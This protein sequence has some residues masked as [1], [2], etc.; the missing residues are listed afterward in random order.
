MNERSHE[1]VGL[2]VKCEKTLPIDFFDA[3]AVEY[4]RLNNSIGSF[5]YFYD[6]LDDAFWC[7]TFGRL[8]QQSDWFIRCICLM[9][10]S[11]NVKAEHVTTT[12]VKKPNGT[13][14][15]R[16]S[17]RLKNWAKN[18]DIKSAQILLPTDYVTMLYCP[19][20]SRAMPSGHVRWMRIARPF[21]RHCNRGPT[22]ELNNS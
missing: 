2:G 13:W 6:Y 3:R 20:E 21:C 9:K 1:S 22:S 12:I 14:H 19:G 4:P 11:N 7:Y 5:F 10:W 17:P 16:S 18:I 8:V 15:C